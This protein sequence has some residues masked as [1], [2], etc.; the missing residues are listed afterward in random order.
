MTQ[1]TSSCCF[2]LLLLLF[3]I[4]LLPLTP[5]QQ[6]RE[7]LHRAIRENDMEEVVSILSGPDGSKLARAKNYYGNKFIFIEEEQEASS[8]F[9][10]LWSAEIKW[11]EFLIIFLF[12]RL[13][14]FN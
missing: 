11:A 9:L 2:F 1:L 3:W 6:R 12:P 14:T 7:D 13:F 8:S 10:V 4:Y 5:E